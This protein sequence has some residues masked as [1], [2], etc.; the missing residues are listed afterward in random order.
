MLCGKVMFLPEPSDG[1]L[2]N[3]FILLDSNEGLLVSKFFFDNDFLGCRA[4]GELI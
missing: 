3:R 2:D 4:T 1:D